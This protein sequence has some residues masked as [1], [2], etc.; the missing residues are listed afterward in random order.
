[1]NS[2]NSKWTK[3]TS[4]VPQGSIL[5]PLL[6]LVYINDK[7]DCLKH[8]EVRLF[9]DDCTTSHTVKEN[10]DCSLLQQDLT[11]LH[12]RT[13]TWQLT[14]NTSKC[15]ALAFTNKRNYKLSYQYRVNDTPLEYVNKFKYLGIWITGNLKWSTHSH[16]AALQASRILNLLCRSLHGCSM[17]PKKTACLALVHPH[18]EY[19][20]PV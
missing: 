19:C 4:G 17:Q 8:S 7:G 13:Q 6:F 18:L 9:A 3:V 20:A 14:L 15:K 10:D 12:R 16:E 11:E 2:S 5:G 1:M